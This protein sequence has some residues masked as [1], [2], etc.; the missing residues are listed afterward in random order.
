MFKE[1]I[2]WINFCIRINCFSY[3]PKIDENNNILTKEQVIM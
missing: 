2:H 1:H 3:N